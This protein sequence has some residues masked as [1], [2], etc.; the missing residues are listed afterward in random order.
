MELV[1]ALK[2]GAAFSATQASK[3][4]DEGEEKGEEA[5]S[6]LDAA[7]ATRLRSKSTTSSADGAISTFISRLSRASTEAI[8]TMG[9]PPQFDPLQLFFE[10]L[11][12]E[13]GGIR[14]DC[15]HQI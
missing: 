7:R 15:M 11:E 1:T 5:T 4:G 3:T 12:I 8:A 14:H 10:Y 6:G 9:P 13:F 2:K